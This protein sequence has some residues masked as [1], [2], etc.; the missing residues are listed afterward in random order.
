MSFGSLGGGVL[1]VKAV[2]EPPQS[3]VRAARLRRRALRRFG[4]KF[5]ENSEKCRF[6]LTIRRS[7]LISKFGVKFLR[8]SA[9]SELEPHPSCLGEG[10]SH[11]TAIPAS[12]P[13][14]AGADRDRIRYSL[15]EVRAEGNGLGGCVRD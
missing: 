5:G 8:M 6:F 10:C 14:C 15:L 13:R 11:L 3:K 2:A 4:K 9:S 1:C 7:R 12:D